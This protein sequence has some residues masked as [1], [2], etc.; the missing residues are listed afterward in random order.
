M[1]VLSISREIKWPIDIGCRLGRN[2]G[3]CKKLL[4]LKS[5]TFCLLHAAKI[6]I[7]AFGGSRSGSFAPPCAILNLEIVSSGTSGRLPTRSTSAPPL[8]AAEPI[9]TVQTDLLSISSLVQCPRG[10]T[11]KPL[12]LQVAHSSPSLLRRYLTGYACLLAVDP[13]S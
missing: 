13:P 6:T 4:A 5:N 10:H 9:A 7:A 11:A 8:C 3:S 2:L 1:P 12:F